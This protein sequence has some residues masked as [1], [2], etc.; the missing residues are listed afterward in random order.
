M[1]YS[2]QTISFTPLLL[3]NFV[4]LFLDILFFLMI[5]LKKSFPNYIFKLFIAIMQKYNFFCIFLV[6]CSCT[7]FIYQPNNFQLTF[8]DVLCTKSSI[9][10]WRSS[11]FFLSDL[12]GFFFFPLTR[13]LSL[14][15][16]RSEQ[17]RYLHLAPD[18]MEKA[19]NL[20][21]LRI[22]LTVD[23]FVDV[24]YEIE[25]SFCLFLVVVWGF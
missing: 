1:L 3:I 19:C 25:E 8:E 15:L 4:D 10:K 7:E 21:P 24:F 6:S 22:I 2:F 16:N 18:L 23:S 17:S 14:V 12:G 9:Y 5:L 13:K 11:H 20:L